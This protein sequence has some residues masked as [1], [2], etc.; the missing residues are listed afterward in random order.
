MINWAYR[1][2]VVPGFESGIKRRK[3]F[4]YWRELEEH[5]WWTEDRIKSLQMQRLRELLNYCDSHSVWYRNRWREHG[6]KLGDVQSLSDLA[7]LP[8]T[9]RQ[10]VQEHACAIRS[11]EA[12]LRYVSKSTG[13]SSGVPLQFVIEN[14]ANDR[15]VAAAFRG[16][17]WAGAEPGTKQSHLWGVR[18]QKLSQGQRIKE[19]IYDRMLYRRDL[20][21][22][23]GITD[24]NV[25]SY[26]QR[27][28][29][30]R[31]KVL[32]AYA[33]PLFVLARAMEEQSISVHRPQSIIVGSEKLYDHQRELIER[34]FG[35]PVYE[36]YGSREFTL[37]AAECDRHQGLHVSSENLI[38]E[39]VDESGKPCPPGTE[40][41]VLVTDLHN[42]AMPFIRYAIGDRAIESP[43]PCGCGRG[44][45]M[46]AKVTGRQ[47]DLLVL[48]DGRKI[49]GIFFPH[50]IKDFPS[51]RQFQVV[52]TERDRVELSLV[53]TNDW[54][55]T[56]QAE[57]HR[58]V[59]DHL[60]PTVQM[61]L[62]F[63]ESIPLTPAGKMRVVIGYPDP[64]SHPP[65]RIAS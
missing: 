6:V 65:T 25:S 56:E 10:M 2:V 13:G 11:T 35:A 33:N 62:R 7:R 37:I 46:L 19:K 18:L 16:Y 5:Q 32:V 50:L 23:F 48:P 58:R 30:Y 39:I 31:P 59:A 29:R 57:L 45:P 41:Q 24:S 47:V 28:N 4:R 53:V 51:V 8:I 20:L 15:R 14:D 60:G 61:R 52:Q 27:I 44:L 63:V 42:R 43:E 54:N 9:T 36:T 55:Q 21:N 17:G 26:V 64:K 34:A 3:T 40:G 22:S 38:V 49:P 12:S 1:K